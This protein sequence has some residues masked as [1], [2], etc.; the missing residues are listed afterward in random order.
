MK[1][2]GGFYRMKHSGHWPSIENPDIIAETI[3][4]RMP[5]YDRK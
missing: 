3:I 4:V 2:S 1:H 5:L